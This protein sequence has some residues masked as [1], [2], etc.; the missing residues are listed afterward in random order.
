MDATTLAVREM[1]EQYP[2][3]ASDPTLRVAADVR[4]LL[5]YVARQR[6]EGRPIH[7]LDA[8]CGR[9]A[10]LLGYASLQPDVNFTGIDLN[11]VALAEVQRG[12]KERNLANVKV[13]EVDLMTLEGLEV[14]E[15]GF[16]VIYSSG[17]LHHLSDPK[18][19][20]EGLRRVLAPHGVIV[21]MVYAEFGRH[22]LDL[23]R[24]SIDRLLPTELPLS[25][26][27]EP[28][29]ALARVMND[30][31]LKETPWATTSEEVDIEFVDRA[32][33][34]N[35][36]SYSLRRFFDLLDETRMRFVRFI[37]P[38]DWDVRDHLPE[39]PLLDAALQLPK[40]TQ[41]EIVERISYRT[42]LQMILSREDNPPRPAHSK[43]TLAGA[44]LLVNP[45]VSFRLE[46]R[47]LKGR[48]RI[49]ELSYI[50][51]S[52]D[53]VSVPNGPLAKAVQIVR[54]QCNPFVG[55]TLLQI[56]C[57]EGLSATQA[58]SALYELYEKEVLFSPHPQDI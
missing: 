36:T 9:G 19:G 22:P 31:T 51:R 58:E 55:A 5:S 39:G 7:A 3:P 53:P 32:L 27:I 47:N 14:P 29:R 8:G 52:Q 18:R 46:T 45:D 33:N 11:R 34:V 12:A 42:N 15:G 28:A 4:L 48:Q 20:L 17:V 23:L 30:T 38:K 16:D 57:D 56:L 40:E 13:Q 24:Q 1:Y 54:D 25:E 50:L 43:S 10:G 49:E 44:P 41:Y 21:V 26:R 35:E 6:P 37:E 2:Y